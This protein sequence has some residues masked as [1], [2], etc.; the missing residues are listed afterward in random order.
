MTT[1]PNTATGWQLSLWMILAFVFAIAIWLTLAT[2]ASGVSVYFALGTGFISVIA[3][4]ICLIEKRYAAML[5]FA[6]YLVFLVSSSLYF[7]QQ[8]MRKK[9]EHRRKQHLLSVLCDSMNMYYA[10]CK[11]YPPPDSKSATA[12]LDEYFAP[13]AI[14]S[15]LDSVPVT[16]LRGPTGNA[17]KW[18]LHGKDSFILIDVGEDGIAGKYVRTEDGFKRVPSDANHDGIDDATDDR[19][20]S[21][22]QGTE[23][24]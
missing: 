19:Y 4:F 17:I 18:E 6:A 8:S 7:I 20:E 12:T 10:N 16:T 24:R 9:V 1:I 14:T 21:R 23:R 13:L 2:K 11:E 15:G 3:F 22:T 5:L